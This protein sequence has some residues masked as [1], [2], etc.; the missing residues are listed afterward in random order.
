MG[1]QQL[2]AEALEL[3]CLMSASPIIGQ[4]DTTVTFTENQR[5]TI[6]D[7]NVTV[8]DADSPNFAGGRV[9]VSTVA[10]LQHADRIG[11]RHTGVG[12]G[13][14]GVAGATAKYGGVSIGTFVGTTTLVVRLNSNATPA[15]VQA[16]LR[17]ITF[18]SISES[19]S[20]L[21]RTINVWLTDGDGGTSPVVSKR[22]KVVATNDPPV[23]LAFGQMPKYPGSNASMILDADVRVSDLDSAN[24]ST[25]RLTVQVT[26]NAA[27]T[28]RLRIRNQGTAAGQIS[29]HLASVRFGGV[30]IGTFFGGNGTRPLVVTLNAASTPAAVQALLRSVTFA[31]PSSM[32]LNRTV[33]VTVSDGAG[34]T[35]ER[36]T[37]TIAFNNL[38]TQLPEDIETF[39]LFTTNSR[40]SRGLIGSYVNQ[41]LRDRPTQDDWRVSQT[42]SGRRRD[43]KIN[44]DTATWGIRRSVGITNGVDSDWEDF[45]VQ[46][47]GFVEITAD[48]TSL[49]TRSDDSSRFW[50][51]LNGD[52]KFNAS[53]PEFIDN[54]WG[55][56]QA[57][58][59]GDRSTPL[60]KGLYRIRIQYEEGFGGSIVQLRSG[61]QHR[62]RVA[63]LIPSNRV[64]QPEGAANLRSNIRNY[65]E[66][67]ADEMDRHGFGRKTFVYETEANGVTPRVHVLQLPNV[68]TAYIGADQG[69][70]HDKILEG[71]EA[72]GISTFAD[73][74]IWLL[75]HEAHIQNADGSK[76]GGVA[77]GGGFGT[78]NAGGIAVVD[79]AILSLLDAD[80][81]RDDRL[82][83][84]LLVPTFGSRL[85]VQDKSFP[86]FEGSTISSVVSSFSG[87]MLHEL[88]HGFGLPHDSRNDN[89]FHGNIMGNGLRGWRGYTYPNRYTDETVYLS[90]ASALT[91]NYSRYLQPA[92]N[93]TDEDQPTVVINGAATIVNG[94]ISIS[95]SASDAEGLGA[96]ILLR[97]GDSVA[98]MSLTGTART[99][100]FATPYYEAGKESDFIVEVIDRAGNKSSATVRFLVPASGN[101]APQPGIKASAAS[102]A[103]GQ[104]IT[105]SAEGT[106]DPDPGNVLQ[107][108][109]DLDGNGTFDTALSSTLTYSISFKT[110]G[111]RLIRARVRDNKGA[112]SVSAPVSVRVVNAAALTSSLMDS[113]YSELTSAGDPRLHR[114][115]YDVF[116]AQT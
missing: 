75:V 77:L 114:Q 45:S 49:H 79:A 104:S 20:V 50:I 63:Y 34:G 61:A 37:M 103:P 51:D 7:S 53:G 96:A 91:L 10:N 89:N 42:I 88:L 39:R 76:V 46:W 16:L 31:T 92:T 101:H 70:T 112:I 78:G 40:T 58:T 29:V 65:Q 81:L 107:V 110:A 32:Q 25:G 90:S 100:T 4:F 12:P 116:A 9:T 71:A 21:S 5:P 8:Q 11:I 44:F 48:G 105:L 82:Y 36:Q 113:L 67:V 52:G 43:A 97:G 87:A 80:G 106:F 85:L 6:I 19:P 73:G 22:V 26:A 3:R 83:D 68:D 86:W 111:V 84:G 27:T 109:W 55:A 94:L 74:D 17:N 98:E 41:S 60:T 2:S 95:F 35:S 54:H 30:T 102:I 59:N 38:P 99:A 13:Q 33:T 57:V 93:Y 24:L 18:S 69:I 1:I 108:E 115:R 66:W 47:D 64:P 62:V 15:S 23:V 28:D 72:V 14:I 56:G